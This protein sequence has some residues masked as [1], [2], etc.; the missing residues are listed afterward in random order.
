MRKM[1][2]IR[3]KRKKRKKA[4]KSEKSEKNQI[5][6]EIAKLSIFSSF[7]GS[8][9]LTIAQVLAQTSCVFI[10][11][12]YSISTQQLRP[13]VKFF[14]DS[15]CIKNLNSFNKKSE[16]IKKIRKNQK[17]RNF[18][19]NSKKT[20]FSQKIKKTPKRKSHTLC[21]KFSCKTRI[22]SL[23]IPMISCFFLFQTSVITSRRTLFTLICSLIQQNPAQSLNALKNSICG[24]SGSF[25]IKARLFLSIMNNF[26]VKN[27]FFSDKSPQRMLRTSDKITSEMLRISIFI[28]CSIIQGILSSAVSF[29]SKKLF[30]IS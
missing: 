16:K 18:L 21:L 10:T 8:K 29:N 14:S 25:T 28:I 7:T 4:K 2:K 6:L 9:T 13:L 1:R 3:K 26:S 22:N 19:K 24:N 12:L 17:N 23:P 5:T 11:L 27:R 15:S 20:K 30:S